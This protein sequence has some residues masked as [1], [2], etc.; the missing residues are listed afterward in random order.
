MLSTFTASPVHRLLVGVPSYG[1]PV[2]FARRQHIR[3][4]SD[5]RSNATL[6]SLGGAGAQQLDPVSLVFVLP[7]DAHAVA[8]DATWADVWR[9]RLPAGRRARHNYGLEKWLLCDATHTHAH[10]HSHTRTHTCTHAPTHSH[11]YLA[12]PAPAPSPLRHIP[13]QQHPRMRTTRCNAFLRRAVAEHPAFDFY[14]IAGKPWRPPAASMLPLPAASW[15]SHGPS[16]PR[17]QMTT[18]SSMLP[19]STP[20]SAPLL[21]TLFR[22]LATAFLQPPRQ[23]RRRSSSVASR[24]GSCGTLTR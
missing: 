14:A 15:T 6:G 21:H 12:T 1:A 13:R 2:A 16:H 22:Q 24:S 3:S 18:L 23:Q 20:G 10:A 11:N 17:V 5:A 8:E 7:Y 4:L 19:R 9:V